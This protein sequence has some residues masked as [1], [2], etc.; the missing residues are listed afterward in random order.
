MT[1]LEVA[2]AILE[3]RADAAR[4][5][6]ALGGR[7][8]GPL[9]PMAEPRESRRLPARLAETLRHHRDLGWREITLSREPFPMLPIPPTRSRAGAR[10]RRM[11]AMQAL[12][13]PA[14]PSCSDPAARM[15]A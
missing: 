8:R 5:R 10:A 1:K 12:R 7:S 4:G 3:P 14:P 13:E 6:R 15:P 9:R 11:H 2:G